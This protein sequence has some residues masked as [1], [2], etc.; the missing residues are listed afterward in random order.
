MGADGHWGSLIVS[1]TDRWDNGSC[2]M[3][4][5]LVFYGC[6]DLCLPLGL[7]FLRDNVLGARLAR[8]IGNELDSLISFVLF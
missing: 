4:L 8:L 2:L 5:T 3:A 1:W 6:S 7:V